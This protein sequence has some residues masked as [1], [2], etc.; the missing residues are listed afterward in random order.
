MVLSHV[1]AQSFLFHPFL[2]HRHLSCFSFSVS[3]FLNLCPL[4]LRSSAD[5]EMQLPSLSAAWAHRPLPGC[6]R[7]L[8][9][10]HKA[11]HLSRLQRIVQLPLVLHHAPLP[12][13][14][15]SGGFGVIMSIFDFLLSRSSRF[16]NIEFPFM[17]CV[18]VDLSCSCGWSAPSGPEQNGLL[19]ITKPAPPE[20]WQAPHYTA[21]IP[22][23]SPE[24]I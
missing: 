21:N 10:V 15:L 2:K 16:R 5:L 13:P 6:V 18:H 12:S 14:P 22:V 7:H 24:E 17:E 19:L 4:W 3:S 20:G 11:I 8:L 23:M 1:Y 9:W